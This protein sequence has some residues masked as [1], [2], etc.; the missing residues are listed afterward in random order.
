M[1]CRKFKRCV[2]ADEPHKFASVSQ[3]KS[4]AGEG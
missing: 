1:Y 2:Q 3:I 4:E